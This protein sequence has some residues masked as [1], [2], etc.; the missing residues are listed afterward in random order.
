MSIYFNS[1]DRPTA[2]TDP[3]ESVAAL[4]YENLIF[5]CSIFVIGVAGGLALVLL[6]QVSISILNFEYCHDLGNIDVHCK[7]AVFELAHL[8]PFTIP[9]AD[10]FAEL[11][12]WHGG[13]RAP[14][15][16]W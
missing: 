9:T 7:I 1:P 6:E 5:P 13:W 10:F 12:M 11:S 8:T 4:G 15:D 16:L 14:E 2:P 3:N